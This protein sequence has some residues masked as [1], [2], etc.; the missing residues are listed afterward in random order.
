MS[1][2][3]QQR[4][5]Y[6]GKTGLCYLCG[7]EAL[8][9]NDHVPPK[10]LA[11]ETNNSVFYYAPA[12]GLCNKSLTDHE[13]RFRNYVLSLAKNN[14]PEANDA[15][16]KMQRGFDRMKEMRGGLPSRDYYRL[17]NNMVIVPS[18]PNGPLVGIKPANDVKYRD[19][20]IKIARG[21]HYYHTE[22]IIPQ[23]YL[24]YADFVLRPSDHLEMLTRICN[25]G[26]IG[27]MGNFFCM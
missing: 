8:L 1:T 15:F 12:C 5:S 21:L 9:T 25:D 3:N 16:E 19:V 10:C 14:V 4:Q 20:L 17:I 6:R 23:N 7:E 2:S 11:P 27:A 18:Y 22:E 13:E 24:K 26:L